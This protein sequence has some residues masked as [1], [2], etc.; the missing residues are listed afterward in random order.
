[1]SEEFAVFAPAVSPAGPLGRSLDFDV[2]RLGFFA[3]IDPSPAFAD[4]LVGGFGVTCK[5]LEVTAERNAFHAVDRSPDAPLEDRFPLTW[6]CSASI[7]GEPSIP[8]DDDGPFPVDGAEDQ[9]AVDVEYFAWPGWPVDI[10]VVG[11][12]ADADAAVIEE[13]RSAL[14]TRGQHSRLAVVRT[15]SGLDQVRIRLSVGNAGEVEEIV[16]SVQAAL[17]GA[18]AFVHRDQHVGYL[19]GRAAEQK[20]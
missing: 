1:V 17:G 18:R 11:S 7:E 14:A 5:G 16:G 2:I 19:L 3:L 15:G 20:R 4:A 6:R 10:T 12:F 13:A 8:S 9:F